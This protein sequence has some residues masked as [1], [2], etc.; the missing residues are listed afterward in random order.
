MPTESE[1]KSYIEAP[2]GFKFM[3]KVERPTHLDANPCQLSQPGGFYFRPPP[4]GLLRPTVTPMG[5]HAPPSVTSRSSSFNFLQPV[6]TTSGLVTLGLVFGIVLIGFLVARDVM[7][8]VNEI[9]KE[10]QLEAESCFR[11][12]TDNACLSRVLARTVGSFIDNFADT[13]SAKSLFMGAGF[14][15]T[16]ITFRSYIV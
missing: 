4:D 10:I 3:A 12:Y 9:G 5:I 11:R 7:H 15:F 1:K 14:I 16:L 13:L 6:L 2:E 8:E